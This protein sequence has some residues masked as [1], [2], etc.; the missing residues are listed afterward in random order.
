MNEQHLLKD[1]DPL[2]P[3]QHVQL[4]ANPARRGITTGR[5]QTQGTRTYVQVEFGPKERRFVDI[6]DLE[7]VILDDQNISDLLL[8]RRF[9]Q[10]GEL[11][12]ILTFYKISSK[13]ANVFY[14]MQTSRTDFYAYQ[15]KPVYKF[16]ES[17][18]GRILIADE[19]GLGKT[20]EAGLIWQEVRARSGANKLLVI[21]PSMLRPKW[22]RELRTKFDVQAE[23]YDTNGFLVLLDDFERE[24]WNFQCAAVCSIEGLRQTRIQE[25]I[26]EFSKSDNRFDLVVIDEAHYLRN[27]GTQT[28]RMGQLISEVTENLIM[29]TAT[30]IHLKNEDLFRLLNVLDSDEY[31]YQY[32][33]EGRIK[34]NEP[35]IAAQNALR[36]IPAD[37]ETAR[38]NVR[39]LASSSWFTKN[40]LT[41]IVASK[42]NNLT[43][44]NHSQLVDASRLL[45]NLNLLSATITRTRKREVQEWRVIR[46]A[47]VL[48][49]K[50]SPREMD[51][52]S[53]ITEVVRKRVGQSGGRAFEAFT[54]MMPQRQ[55]ASCIPAMIEHYRDLLLEG[56]KGENGDDGEVEGMLEEDLGFSREDRETGRTS[57]S[58][59]DVELDSLVSGWDMDYPD[60]K[61][62]AL[63]K[64]L[65][66]LF[67]LEPTVKIVV[68]SYFKRTL[69]YLHRRLTKDGF[70]PAL[71]HGDID[72]EERQAVI[73]SFQD[74]PECRILLSSEVGSEGIDLQFCRVVV[75][76]D[77]PW[78][79]MKV[80]QR[81]GRLDRIGQESEKISVINIAAR[82][83]IE[84][85]I[86]NRLYARIGIFERSIGDLEPILGDLIQQLTLDLLSR[87]LTPQQEEERIE[88]T[89]LAL[90]EKRKQEADLEDTSSLFFGSSDFILEQINDARKTGRWITPAELRSYITDFF[91]SHYQGTR[92][93]WDR[94]AEGQVSISL[95]NDARSDLSYFC[96]H[97]R[98]MR[99]RLIQTGAD[100]VV[101]GYTNEAIRANTGLEFLSH[102]HPLVRWVTDIY[103]THEDPFY[104]VSAVE[105]RTDLVELGD[106]IFMIE[107]WRFMSIQEE[108]QISYAVVPLYE[109]PM[110]DT[111]TAEK[112][113]QEILAHGQNWAYADRIVDA[114]RI[115]GALS[116]CNR[117]LEERREAA[118]EIFQ[119]R[120]TAAF[121][122]KSAH[123]ENHL[124][125]KKES[126]QR[127]LEKLQHRLNFEILTEE[128]RTKLQR[129]MK[130]DKTKL[131]NLEQK[132]G[133]QLRALEASSKCRLEFEEVAGGI[134]RVLG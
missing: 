113:L 19:V 69:A 30:P 13:L 131:E 18:N 95:S 99:T 49:L 57:V 59:M 91:Q 119:S 28:H 10:K 94:P 127:S 8:K 22:K 134:C 88:Q 90:E 56:E 55:M 97:Q 16:I 80:E 117:V 92:I 21:C 64:E 26:E 79:P 1:F 2:R 34:A 74:R 44:D 86:L 85:R 47:R 121:Q 115:E 72:M 50:F 60:S 116:I 108:L 37:L 102:F 12:R 15:F 46:D 81:I 6:E 89:R 70:P 101:L 68:F 40:P 39:K 14:A 120:M 17:A 31:P 52:Y 35:V 67:A 82:E 76:Y 83:T 25:A 38:K 124:A 123:L 130:G 75:N 62:E 9:G 11:A 71:I 110:V 58:P 7:P 132:V 105:V 24:T 65:T 66:R 106:Y 112:L 98:E 63:T 54:L 96:R 33:F 73:E 41:G 126:F 77:L 4:R 107:L 104:P 109:G 118:Y 122:R 103:K 45:E 100:P 51:F 29:L 128:Q 42:V 61:Y 32:L 27:I 87:K 78:N 48:D 20:I 114:T 5:R 53:R 84:E 93:A 3:N 23:I 43:T 36:R 129:K 111:A 133:E 125:R